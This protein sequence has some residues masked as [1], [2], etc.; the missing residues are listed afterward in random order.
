[1]LRFALYNN[2]P[3]KLLLAFMRD[4]EREAMIRRLRLAR[5]TARTITHRGDLAREC[6]RIR[7]VGYSVDFAEADEGIHCVA[8]PL[9]DPRGEVIATIWV[10]APSRR[11]LKASFPE[12][13][14]LVRRAAD[15]ITQRIR[16]P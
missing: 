3:G 16:K 11:L 14:V 12:T 7:T 15:K 6:D 9:F 13:G 1:G 4:G 8:A 5:C 10:S 2:A